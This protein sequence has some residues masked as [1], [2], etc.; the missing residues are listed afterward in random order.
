MNH[1]NLTHNIP[2]DIWPTYLMQTI[3]PP[4]TYIFQASLPP[5]LTL[6]F[7]NTSF[8]RK[9]YHTC[10]PY[11][12]YYETALT[13]SVPYTSR[14]ILIQT[15]YIYS[16]YILIYLI[17]NN[18]YNYC[19]PHWIPC[20]IPPYLYLLLSIVLYHNIMMALW[21]WNNC[22]QTILILIKQGCVR[23]YFIYSYFIPLT[24]LDEKFY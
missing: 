5:T 17:S 3:A 4:C 14:C 7:D 21:G 13:T 11:Q 10:N 1:H 23:Q 24:F 19:E 12:F 6:I 9:V 15:Y 22:S 16:I 18:N 20:G 8:T 2:L